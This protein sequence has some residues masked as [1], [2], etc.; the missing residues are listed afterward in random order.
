MMAKKK[1]K[2]TPKLI[3]LIATFFIFVIF[4]ILM[5]LGLQGDFVAKSYFTLWKKRIARFIGNLVIFL[6][7]IKLPKMKISER[8]K[9]GLLFMALLLGTL[10]GVYALI[11]FLVSLFTSVRLDNAI[12]FFTSYF[13]CFLIWDYLFFK[14]TKGKEGLLGRC[15]DD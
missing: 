9:Y 5:M 4:F 2:L 8:L 12:L 10:G 3:F 11:Y 13:L 1:V 6:K 14:A 7:G 15:R